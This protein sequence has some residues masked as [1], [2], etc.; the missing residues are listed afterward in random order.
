VDIGGANLK[1][2][3]SDGTAYLQPFELWKNPTGL[4]DALRD[5]L[6]RLPPGD[7]L[8]ATMTG[9]LCD[10]FETK[11]QGVQAI[12]D[13]VEK[14]IPELPVHVWQNDGRFVDVA[15]ARAR[16]LQTAAA[17]WLAL[18]T[19]AARFAP[20]G[21]ALLIDIGSTTTDVVPLSEGR[22]VPRGRT[23]PERLK[24]QELVYTGVRRT[25]V[26]ALAGG[27]AELFATT[28]DVF[29]TLGA[30][31]E[32]AA[33]MHTADGRP[34]TRTAAH[35]RLARMLCADAETC[36]TAE[37]RKLAERVCLRQVGHLRF[38]VDHVSK[39][40]PQPPQ[41]IIQS[42]SG[43]FLVHV[44]LEQAPRLAPRR[45]SLAQELGP[46]VSQAA[47]AYAGPLAGPARAGPERKVPG[48]PAP[49]GCGR[50]GP[51]RVRGV[52]ATGTDP[53]PRPLRVHAAR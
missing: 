14:A 52:M 15:T 38:A 10:C 49:S 48:R 53:C 40:L 45:I 9:E 12:L 20:Q 32:D 1:A 46:G 43:E 27:V 31:P 35:A 18:A 30:V 42:G 3:H 19:I 28:L 23:D 36:T 24:A 21:P 25:P 44:V 50:G 17:N 29:L 34:A 6:R 41:T 33:D 16:P 5:L 7:V 26:C 13:A 37:T 8:A 4:A 39:T 51:R 22:P 11:R 2:A 47:C